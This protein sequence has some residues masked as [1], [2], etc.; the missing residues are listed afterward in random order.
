M[1][2]KYT[3]TRHDL[4]NGRA[5][6][7]SCHR[8]QHDGLFDWPELVDADTLDDLR[9][10][11]RDHTPFKAPPGYY[12]ELRAELKDILDELDR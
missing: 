6:C 1:S 10:L 9:R 11:K 2:R 5:L 7:P 4:R 12:Q 8:A 3:V